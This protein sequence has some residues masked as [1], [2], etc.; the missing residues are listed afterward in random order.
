[1]TDEDDEHILLNREFR[2]AVDDYVYNFPAGL[3]DAGETPELTSARFA[4]SIRS[5]IKTESNMRG[6]AEYRNHLAGVLV[7]RAVLKLEG[8]R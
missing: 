1:M 3:V 2:M 6:S 7:K 8:N 4:A 5:R